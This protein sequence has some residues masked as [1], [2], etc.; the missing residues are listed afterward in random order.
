[1]G[2]TIPIKAVEGIRLAGDAISARVFI[3]KLGTRFGAGSTYMSLGRELPF[4]VHI[5][6]N[7]SRSSPPW[8]STPI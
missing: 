1:T 3:E 2:H 7:L 6:Q 8:R 4:P 5:I